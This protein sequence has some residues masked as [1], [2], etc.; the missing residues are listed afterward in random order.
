MNA[1]DTQFHQLHH[2][3]LLILTNV[4]DATGA[5]LV[6]QLG[7]KAVA[8]SSA[9]VAWAH[10]YPDGNT[11]P[12][13]RLISTVESIARV[14][15]VPLSVDIEAGY[16]DD[17]DR[18]A[19][20]I[21]AVVAAGAVGINIEDGNGTPELLARKI[22]VARQVADK[23]DVKLF[24]NARTDVYLKSLVPAEDRVA[25]TLHRAALY[26]AAGA[27][28][29]FAA[30]ATSAY[31]IEAICKGTTLPVNVLGFACLPSPEELKTLGV[32]RLSAG[33]GIAE[34]LYGAM[35]SLV[36]S[37]LAS[38]KLDTHDLKA[39]TYGEVNGLLK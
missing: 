1:L 16:S 31:E 17:L 12:L 22:E 35:G 29:L 33:S 10:G 9:A 8:T 34:F 26:Q 18:V 3:G 4:A 19:E 38:G 13:E 11:L 24:I 36:K 21:D 28:G 32:R 30:G 20:V 27:D 37:F 15:K 6:E 2:D 7:G 5:R 14:I 23:R 25:E 39:F